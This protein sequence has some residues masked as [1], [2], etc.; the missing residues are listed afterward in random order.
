MLQPLDD[1]VAQIGSRSATSSQTAVRSS[2]CIRSG[3]TCPAC[4]A[5]H[6]PFFRSNGA[7]NPNSSSPAV[8]R[9]S[10]RTKRDPIRA[11]TSS[12]TRRQPATA[13]L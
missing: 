11:T 6:Q 4:S 13:T 2:R 5:S 9:V 1:Q 7:S 12:N 8:C 3:V 10:D